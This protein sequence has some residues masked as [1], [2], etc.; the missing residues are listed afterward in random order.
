[1]PENKQTKRIFLDSPVTYRIKIQGCLEEIWS[2]RLA[3]MKITM[4]I[5]VQ[6]D[7]VTTLAGQVKDQSELIGVLNSL[8]EL[9]MPILS[10]E[11]IPE[12]EDRGGS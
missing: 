1:M 4:H 5:Q 6:Q 8:Y 3:G 11:M 12:K 7:S 2:D 9:R 10:L